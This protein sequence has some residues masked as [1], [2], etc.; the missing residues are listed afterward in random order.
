MDAD[1]YGPSIPH[2]LGLDERPSAVN[3]RLQPIIADACP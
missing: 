1:V 3:N 2:L